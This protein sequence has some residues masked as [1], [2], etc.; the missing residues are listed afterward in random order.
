MNNPD[1]NAA[2]QDAWISKSQAKR[3]DAEMQA[4]GRRLVALSRAQIEQFP[5]SESLRDA[6]LEYKRI[7]SH[8]AQRRH[9]KR[10]G[11]LLR[12]HAVDEVALALDRIDPSSS[13][14]MQ[15]TQS[16][17]RWVERLVHD[18]KPALTEL[19]ERY[20]Q[21]PVQTL[22]QL[23]RKTRKELSQRA[24][25]DQRPSPSQRELLRLLRQCIVQQT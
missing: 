16:A 9:V 19:V 13:L 12:E 11:K 17:Q 3:D 15:A 22:G 14:S 23:L 25:D 5:V 8:E 21:I 10:V 7:R 2:E 24:E 1:D 4:L 18:G 6:L 20:P